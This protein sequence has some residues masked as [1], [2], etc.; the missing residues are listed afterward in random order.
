MKPAGKDSG[1]FK[2]YGLLLVFVVGMLG[3]ITRAID[4]AF[5]ISKGS[6]ASDVVETVRLCVLL[7]GI[8]LLHRPI[9][10]GK[11][12]CIYKP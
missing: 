12:P 5:G 9:Y 2:L 10:A 6:D 8:I 7:A 1:K 11:W 3:V 4:F